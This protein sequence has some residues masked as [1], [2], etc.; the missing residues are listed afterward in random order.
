MDGGK[1]S[2]GRERGRDDRVARACKGLA[3]P[4]ALCE[5]IR[6]HHLPASETQGLAAT[7]GAVLR[8]VQQADLLSRLFLSGQ[9]P[10]DLLPDERVALLEQR[11]TLPDWD[12]MPLSG[13]SLE[14]LL[15]PIITYSNQLILS[16]G[17]GVLRQ[18][19]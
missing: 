3:I 19:K 9:R 2:P 5:L 14:R 13:A 1:R 4:P 8:I 17:I 10:F 15:D 11:C 6:L 12:W 18:R 7:Q 16:V